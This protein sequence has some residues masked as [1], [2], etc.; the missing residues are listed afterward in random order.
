MDIINK[1]RSDQMT[2]NLSFFSQSYL[3]LLLFFFLRICYIRSVSDLKSVFWA[4]DK[5]G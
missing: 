3:L 1:Y 2:S 4:L 5:F